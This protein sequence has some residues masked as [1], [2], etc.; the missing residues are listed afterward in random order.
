[1]LS[2]KAPGQEAPEWNIIFVGKETPQG[3]DHGS[4]KRKFGANVLKRCTW[5]QHFRIAF[6]SK[7]SLLLDWKMWFNLQSSEKNW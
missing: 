4:K 1:M 5:N 6:F 3:D 7:R 2:L